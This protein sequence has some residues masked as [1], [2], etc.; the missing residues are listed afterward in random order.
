[1]PRGGSTEEP[2]APAPA[3][4][5]APVPAPATAAKAPSKPTSSTPRRPASPKVAEPAGPS[6]GTRTGRMV[7]TALGSPPTKAQ[8]DAYYA[9]AS[10]RAPYLEA[11]GRVEALRRE[12]QIGAVTRPAPP[13]EFARKPKVTTT[14]PSM[15]PM[16]IPA[17]SRPVPQG[18]PPSQRG[19][20]VVSPTQTPTPLTSDEL[21][22]QTPAQL[23]TRA[24]E[25]G[26]QFTDAISAYRQAR[27]TTDAAV[28]SPDVAKSAFPD[29]A[30]EQRKRLEAVLS[31]AAQMREYGFVGSNEDLMTRFAPK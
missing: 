25:T 9:A 16:T 4:A 28:Q 22:T 12:G 19:P 14:Y 11:L 27:R 1:M 18:A 30:A 26:R 24:M 6:S 31:L 17:A 5:P 10:D 15:Q 20:M 2:T 21:R 13:V 29:L 7:F 8:S 3:P 23:A